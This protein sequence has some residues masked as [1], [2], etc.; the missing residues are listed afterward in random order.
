M[1]RQEL[2]NRRSFMKDAIG[3]TAA[4]TIVPRHVLGG[5]GYTAPSDRLTKAV[6]GCGIMGHAHIAS[7]PNRGAI[8]A[9]C[10]V[11]ENHLQNA[12]NA[13]GNG[14]KG[15]RDFREVLDRQDIDVVII[16]TPPHWHGLIA[17]AAADAGKDIVCEKPMTRTIAE[18]QKLVEAVRRNGTILRVNTWGRFGGKLAGDESSAKL[19]KKL[20]NSGMLGL[21]LRVT[22]SRATGFSKL[23]GE[24]LGEVD[25]KPQPVPPELDYNMWLGP[26]PYKP[27]HPLRVHAVEGYEGGEGFRGYWDYDGGNLGDMGQHYLDPVQY[28]MGKD[29]TSPVE[30]IPDTTQQ[31]PDAVRPWHQVHMKYADETELILESVNHNKDAPFIEGPKG[32]LYL[33]FKSDIPNLKEKVAALPDPEPQMTN[34]QLAIRTRQR[35]GLNEQ[36]GHRSCSLINL[37][38]IAL[39][40]GRPLRYEPDKQRFINDEE[41]NRFINQPM[42][43]PWHL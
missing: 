28:V 19:V 39:R 27:Y 29:D 21:P 32:K 20:I 33:G 18:G 38:K 16:A 14:V 24:F 42:R 23:D 35:F 7:P 30:I 37:G 26:A 15:Y 9:V 25:L 1:A 5:S 3:T 22:V 31:H 40:L 6:I 4:F 10:D 12:V 11:D 34:F 43:A 36:N 13:V 8:L 17:I 41:A 2:I